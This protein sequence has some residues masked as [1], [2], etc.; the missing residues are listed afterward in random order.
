[1]SGTCTV[2]RVLVTPVCGGMRVLAS[3]IEKNA[4]GARAS[5]RGRNGIASS[6]RA[7]TGQ[8]AI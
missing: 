7:V 1:M 8:R 3:R 5:I 4:V 6:V 2:R